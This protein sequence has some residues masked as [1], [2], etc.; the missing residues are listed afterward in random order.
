MIEL[1]MLTSREDLR[2]ITGLP[3]DN[4]DEALW[5]A[6]FNLDDWDVCFVS[7]VPLEEDDDAYWLLMRM[8]SYCVGYE[9]VEYGGKYFYIAYHSQEMGCDRMSETKLLPCPFCGGGAIYETIENDSF[10][11]EMP[12]IF[13]NWC[14]IIFK[15]EDD[16]PFLSYKERYNYLKEKNAKAW[17]TRLPIDTILEKFEEDIEEN[18][19][20]SLGNYR[21]GL[22]RA[23]E[24]VK[25][26]VNEC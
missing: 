21:A 12:V 10:G 5:D 22:Y 9:H 2:K 14:K 15:A 16:S 19:E 11:E 6:G 24:I 26:E 20:A 3:S 8:E 18:P 23:I 13:C 7:D 4:H 25:E 1:K 17:N